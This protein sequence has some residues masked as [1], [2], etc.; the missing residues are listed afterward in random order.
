MDYD[1]KSLGLKCGLEVHQQLDTG[2]LFSRSPSILREDKTDFTI[3][4]FLRPVASETGEYDRAALEAHSK[5]LFYN[6]EGYRDTISL[7]ELDEEPTQP[8]DEEA[9]R[10]VLEIALLTNSNIVDEMFAMRKMVIDGSNTSGFQRTMLVATGGQIKL[11]EAELGVQTIVIEENSARA[12]EKTDK[13]ITYRLD[14]LGIP[15]IEL[16]TAPDIKT[17]QQAKEAARAIGNLFRRTGRV[18]RGLGTIRQD[19]NVSISGGARVEIKGVQELEI[20]DEYVKREVQRQKSLLEIKEELAKRGAKKEILKSTAKDITP[21]FSS[22]EAKIIKNSI[23]RNDKILALKLEKFAGIIGRE[24]QPNRRLGTEF[25]DHVKTKTGLKGLFHSD[26]L[27]NYGISQEEVGKI[28]LELGCSSEDAFVMVAGEQQ[29]CQNALAAVL[30]R[31][32]QCFIGV[33]EETRGAIDA[34]NSEYLRPLPGAA[35][36]YPETDLE[37]ICVE[38]KTLKQIKSSLPLT[39][40]QRSQLYSKWGLNENHIEQM[41]L[42]NFARLFER[43]VKNGADAKKTAV[44]LLEALIEARRDGAQIDNL[45]EK[46]LSEFIDGIKSGKITKEIQK[47][48]IIEKSANHSLAI[49]QLLKS[50]GTQANSNELQKVIEKIVNSNIALIKEKKMGSLA[51]LMGD[52]MKELKGRASGKEVSEELKRQIG[53]MV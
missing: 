23:L 43:E 28:K 7:V 26:E 22:T 52:S 3:K 13:H 31:A 32:A 14:R 21:L 8:I 34:G 50:K 25:A 20:I 30:Q 44:F 5:G 18:K 45:H 11:K 10:T 6:Y 51:A 27:P 42:S 2:K 41:K 29:K 15:L 38:Q 17:P 4:R 9:F 53:K 19:L 36:M 12:I 49:T 35:R 46:E 1:Y 40:D 48:L 47:E 24:V 33:P 16:A 37:T 39:E